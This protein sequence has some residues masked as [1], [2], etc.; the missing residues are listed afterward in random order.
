MGCGHVSV[1]HAV[2][3]SPLDLAI[4]SNRAEVTLSDLLDLYSAGSK[5]TQ[6]KCKIDGCKKQTEAEANVLLGRIA[7]CLIIDIKHPDKESDGGPPLHTHLRAPTEPIDL[8][9]WS[10]QSEGET[11]TSRWYG[12]RSIVLRSLTE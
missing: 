12:A 3:C 10:H 1:K 4:P 5:M 7:D 9:S 2:I 6:H 8:S 11:S